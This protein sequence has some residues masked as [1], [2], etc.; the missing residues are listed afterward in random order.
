MS[1]KTFRFAGVSTFNGV[2]KVRFANSQDRSKVLAGCGCGGID[3]I[4]LKHPM[5]KLEAVQYLLDINF[6]NGNTAVR[7]AL[8]RALAKRQPRAAAVVAPTQEELA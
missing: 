2:T 7:D 4:E 5:E 8:E 1:N 6:D 3:L